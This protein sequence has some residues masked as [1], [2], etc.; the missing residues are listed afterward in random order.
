MTPT[1]PTKNKPGSPPGKRALALLNGSGVCCWILAMLTSP[2]SV[3]PD[4]R[5]LLA[6]APGGRDCLLII[7]QWTTHCSNTPASDKVF[8]SWSSTL[9]LKMSRTVLFWSSSAPKWRL[10]FGITNRWQIS[11]KFCCYRFIIRIAY[12]PRNPK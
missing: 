6:P 1:M 3:P 12:T 10:E 7:R 9:P 2:R 8:E 11:E 5:T 4:L